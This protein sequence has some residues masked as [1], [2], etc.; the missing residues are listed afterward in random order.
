MKNGTKNA[1]SS[2]TV[3][4]GIV[5]IFF[6]T[7]SICIY[8][9][10]ISFASIEPMASNDAKP[11][12]MGV[13][14]TSL[15]A[16]QDSKT[17]LVDLNNSA[18]T[19]TGTTTSSRTSTS[20]GTGFGTSTSTYTSTSP[21]TSTGTYTSTGM[22]TNTGTYTTTSPYTSTYTYTSTSAYTNT[23]TYTSTSMYTNTGTGTGMGTS[24]STNTG[25]SVN[26]GTTPSTS[27]ATN[28]GTGT[29]TNTGTG[30][31][32]PADIAKAL[33]DLNKF[34]G[35]FSGDVPNTNQ[36]ECV[37]AGATTGTSPGS[38][39][40]SVI[41]TKKIYIFG[42]E[43]IWA[44]L[45][46]WL[47]K[48]FGGTPDPGQTSVRTDTETNPQ[49]NKSTTTTTITDNNKQVQTQTGA[50]GKIQSATVTDKDG[51]VFT[52]TDTNG[53]GIG[54]TKVPVPKNP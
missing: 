28:T 30:T 18:S 24:S 5:C 7:V 13:S 46:N 2:F 51:N 43:G 17:S 37:P 14:A 9:A 52:I 42:P 21:Y 29:N 3:F 25:T 15:Q 1:F 44:G 38:G 33:A 50:D 4:L 54:D 47:T 23:G 31:S 11:M 40:T 53:D 6:L 27:T 19:Y 20:T 34:M 10:E 32:I 22:Y 35:K 26:T 12:P 36:K 16:A 45:W 49:N 41:V 8:V 48:S 39:G